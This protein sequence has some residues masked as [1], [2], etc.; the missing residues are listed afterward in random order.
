MYGFEAVQLWDAKSVNYSEILSNIQY[1]EGN[2]RV[3]F[4]ASFFNLIMRTSASNDRS[5]AMT[6]LKVTH[7]CIKEQSAL[8]AM[9]SSIYSTL[10]HS[11]LKLLT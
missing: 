11:Q 4:Q 8:P 9:L 7:A 3:F 10:F 5:E 1:S 2:T 6:E